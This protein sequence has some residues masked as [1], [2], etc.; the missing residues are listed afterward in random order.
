[1]VESQHRLNSPVS[2]WLEQQRHLLSKLG[3]VEGQGPSGAG[4]DVLD[5]QRQSLEQDY[6]DSGSGGHI[7][8]DHP[9]AEDGC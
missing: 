1:M 5:H 3:G 8:G 9:H 6:P 4:A 7:F 2:E